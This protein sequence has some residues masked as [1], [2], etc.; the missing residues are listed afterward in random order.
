[1]KSY[2]S[3]IIDLKSHFLFCCYA[4]FDKW[5]VSYLKWFLLNCIY[6]VLISMCDDEFGIELP[7]H[8]TMWLGNVTKWYKLS[9]MLWLLTVIYQVYVVRTM[10]GQKITIVTT[11]VASKKISAADNSCQTCSFTVSPP[12]LQK[13]VAT[14][15]I[16]HLLHNQANLRLIIWIHL[17]CTQLQD[18]WISL[19]YG[20]REGLYLLPELLP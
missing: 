18:F 13:S 2:R 17:Q 19:Y 7:S 14:N 10:L 1:M 15:D 8:F 9:F 16:R 11:S 5:S 12:R 3:L 4:L 6:H 20:C